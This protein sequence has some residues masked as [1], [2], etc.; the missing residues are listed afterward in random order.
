MQVFKLCMKILKKKTPALLIYAGVFL[1][2]LTLVAVMYT[3]N[4]PTTSSFSPTKG[5]IAFLSVE[6]TPLTE[7]LRKELS[8]T[9]TIVAV[10]DKTEAL[11]DALFFRSV[12]YIVRI[13]EGFTEQFMAGKN[14]AL[15]KT[16]VPGSI[17]QIDL[18]LSIN[19]YLNLARLYVANDPT[20]TPEALAANVEKDL[21]MTAAIE[22]KESGTKAAAL[23]YSAYY[24]NY[25]AYIFLSVLILGISALMVVFNNPELKRR[26][27]C[28]PIPSGSVNLQ[29]ILANLLF[30]LIVWAIMC[31]FFFLLNPRTEKFANFGYFLL[32]AFVF[33]LCAASISYLIGIS[34]KGQSAVSAVSNTVALGFSFLSGVFVPQELI[35]APVL[36]IAS[37]TPTYWY[38]K[39]NNQIAAQTQTVGTDLKPFLSCL[40]IEIGFAM[41]FLVLAL[42][43]GKRKN[44]QFS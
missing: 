27:A 30:T 31:S 4:S 38:V 13:P 42:V 26:N 2:V 23:S 24:F 28:S 6:S 44:I 33:A 17:S 32:N 16:I 11:Q 39:A 22:L 35:A 36:R 8:K 43:V 20:L 1:A 9:A 15:E 19:Q 5:K 40:L 25:L 10:P 21:S 29:F 41:A 7:G 3:K 34:V 37:F 12:T 14:V 18:D